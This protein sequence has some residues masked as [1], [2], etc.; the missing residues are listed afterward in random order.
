MA[1]NFPNSASVGQQF[2]VNGVTREW[3]GTA[4]ISVATTVAGPQG[5]VGPTSVAAS[6][7]Y[8]TTSGST[9]QTTFSNM[10]VSGNLNV[11][12][13]IYQSGSIVTISASNLEVAD[14]IIYLSASNY[15]SDLLDIGFYGAYGATGHDSASNHYHTGLVRDH[16]DDKWKLFSAGVE[17]SEGT[18]DFTSAT[19]DTL[20]LGAI[21]V[22]SSAQ[23]SNLNAQYLAGIESASYARLDQAQT[24]TG[25][26]TFNNF[27]Q[28][29]GNQLQSGKMTLGQNTF[30]NNNMLTVT[31]NASTNIGI[32]VKG[33]SAQTAN[34]QEWQN[35]SATVLASIN[36][37]GVGY[38]AGISVSG[39]SVF[40]YQATFQN[41]TITPLIAKNLGGTA[42]IQQWQNSSGSVLA[43]VT[44]SGQIYTGS[45]VPLT[46]PSGSTAQLS[47]QGTASTN[48]ALIVRGSVN[49]NTGANIQEWQRAD[50]SVQVYVRADGYLVG[51]FAGSKFLYDSTTLLSTTTSQ[52]VTSIR[53]LTGQTADLTQWQNNVSSSVLAG[54][55]A[56][57]QIYTGSAGPLTNTSGSAAQLSVVTSGST[58]PGI[59]IRASASQTADLM[60]F[61]SSIGG[62]LSK[63]DSLGQYTGIYSLLV[64]DS[65]GTIPLRLKGSASQT[66]NL[67][68]WQNSSGSVIA[69]I[70][71]SGT[72]YATIIDGGSA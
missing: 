58:T 61:Q 7:T 59:I 23:V 46:N 5:P 55:T 69:S 8:A 44:A 49:T 3:D 36:N 57:G 51:N 33:A 72:L 38:F 31:S 39:N 66:A 10:N 40:N 13:N 15:Y 60:Q 67:Q 9:Q 53:G 48:P 71:A 45:S 18:I 19:Y 22:S 54:V 16:L 56:S 43:G 14:S 42:N 65:A 70:S 17:P 2:T 11:T 50:G 52:I 47:V 34:L 68:E 6:V 20:K 64:S 30:N 63:F 24:F 35:A 37:G 28:A 12:G 41:S 4:W 62:V 26:Q 1:S 25:T 32:A 27:V 21:E 29:Y